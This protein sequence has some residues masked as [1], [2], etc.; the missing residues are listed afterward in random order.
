[1]MEARKTVTVVFSDVSSSTSLGERLDPEA[2][3][4]VMERYFAEARSVLERHGGT[5]EKFI[6]DAVMACFGVPTA[7][8]DDALRA[9][10]AVAELRERLAVL[11]EELARE[12]GVRLGVRTGVNTRRSWATRRAGSSSPRAMR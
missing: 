8:E 12:P 7:H 2:L 11:N 5:V 10:R 1:M 3:R 6:G 9:V 4:H